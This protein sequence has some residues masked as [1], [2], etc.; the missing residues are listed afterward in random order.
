MLRKAALV[1][2]YQLHCSALIQG[3]MCNR[4]SGVPFM[5]IGFMRLLLIPL[6]LFPFQLVSKLP[7]D[8]FL[9]SGWSLLCY[10]LFVSFFAAP[11]IYL[12]F[13][14]GAS[15]QKGMLQ[16]FSDFFPIANVGGISAI[17]CNFVRLILNGVYFTLC[18]SFIIFS[19]YHCDGRHCVSSHYM[20]GSCKDEWSE[21]DCR[22]DVEI[23]Y[24]GPAAEEK[25]LVKIFPLSLVIFSVHVYLVAQACVIVLFQSAVPLQRAGRID[26]HQPVTWSIDIARLFLFSSNYVLMRPDTMNPPLG[27]PKWFDM[28]SFVICVQFLSWLLIFLMT[29]EEARIF[30]FVLCFLSPITVLL[31]VAVVVTFG[32]DYANSTG[33]LRNFLTRFYTGFSTR[34]P[35]EQYARDQFQIQ[36]LFWGFLVTFV[37]LSQSS[38]LWNGVFP[39]LGR[40]AGGVSTKRHT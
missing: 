6:C 22:D 21:G 36:P 7:I 31:L 1:L 32:L 15:L 37:H 38:N 5:S 19:L 13:V 33:Q 8:Q 16:N 14:E 18:I 12:Q 10:I 40:W 29:F 34:I 11:F 9:G 4:G 28:D 39:I 3:R 17:V 2:V 27:F 30:I 23:I 26:I 25:F 24:S 20:W 35:V